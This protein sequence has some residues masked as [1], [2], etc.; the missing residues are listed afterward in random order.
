[1]APLLFSYGHDLIEQYNMEQKVSEYLASSTTTPSP[2]IDM[3][4]ESSLAFDNSVSSESNDVS[5]DQSNQGFSFVNI[6]WA[7]FSTGL[8]SVLAVVLAGF[9]L[10]LIHI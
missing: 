2:A 9:F 4:D 5:L 10:S 7:S 6:H 8:S 3:A 1:M